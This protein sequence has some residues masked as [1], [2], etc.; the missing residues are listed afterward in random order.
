MD[1]SVKRMLKLIEEEGDSFAQKAEIYI[2]KRPELVSQVEDFYRMFRSLAE[3]YDDATCELRRTLPAD[4]RS[5]GCGMNEICSAPQSAITSPEH[6]FSRR[7]SGTHAAFLDAV[8][9]KGY[10]TS[11]YDSSSDQDP[12]D[13]SYYNYS[14]YGNYR[15]LRGKITELEGELRKL[16]VEQQVNKPNNEIADYEEEL[17]VAKEKIQSSEEEICELKA[18]LEKYEPLEYDD[19]NVSDENLDEY[20]DDEN[21]TDDEYEQLRSERDEL[22]MKLSE[23]E[24]ETRL[25]DDQIDELN[26]RLQKL[27]VECEE[28]TKAIEDLR[29]VIEKQRVMIEEGVEERVEAERQLSISLEH[30]RNAYQMLRKGL[31]EQKSR[32]SV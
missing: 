21:E 28:S 24:E 18:R 6:R 2:Q 20:M 4:I 19:D 15:R 31:R 7:L 32:D 27:Q 12:D 3:R 14:N 9:N 29:K 5:Q 11:T 26:D 17:R 16:Q 30:Y 8:G 25:K 22:V 13:S 10:E 1:R 23:L